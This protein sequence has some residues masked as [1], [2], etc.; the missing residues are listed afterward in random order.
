M[1]R[2]SNPYR[3]L[4]LACLLSVVSWGC[5]TDSPTA[6]K[7]VPPPVPPGPSQAYFITVSADPGGIVI[8]DSAPSGAE[9][10]TVLVEIRLNG[11]SGP[12]P[13]DGTTMLVTTSLGSFS[14]LGLVRQTGVSVVN[15][16]TFLTLFSGGVV[17]TPPQLGVAS[18]QAFREG[19]RG[20]ASVPITVLEANFE[21]SNPEENLSVTFFDESAGNPSDF[22]WDFGDGG[23]S[24]L[25]NPHHLYP[26]GGTYRAK[27][28]VSKTIAGVEL[29]DSITKEVDV[30]VA[31]VPPPPGP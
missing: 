15:G 3:L 26:A 31:V 29:T 22:L 17:G 9:S 8:S 5:T 19:S 14:N 18:V 13:A 30:A 12:R 20:E 11:P 16:Q 7:Q 1:R 4:A 2:F 24:S 6:P 28:T 10:T 27:L 25:Q 21:T 23:T